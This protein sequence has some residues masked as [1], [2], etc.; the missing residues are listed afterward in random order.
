[1]NK[2][3]IE[4]KTVM[5]FVFGLAVLIFVILYVR[6]G[7]QA[8]SKIFDV[9]ADVAACRATV[10]LMSAEKK[11]PLYLISGGSDVPIDCVTNWV[12]NLTVKETDVE[13]QKKEVLDQVVP[14]VR[15]CWYEFGEGKLDPFASKLV[16]QPNYCFICSRFVIDFDKMTNLSGADYFILKKS[17][18]LSYLESN[19][20]GNMYYS[21]YFN[22]T[23]PFGDPFVEKVEWSLSL[24]FPSISEDTFYNFDSFV[25]KGYENNDYGVVMFATPAKQVRGLFGEKGW[26]KVFIIPYSNVSNLDCNELIKKKVTE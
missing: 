23:F 14:L 17:D 6:S 18:F 9:S 26:Y 4:A 11:T 13:K 24:S 22:D 3:G 16:S 8:S 2:K 15:D 25:D 12:G 19:K 7:G 20:K 5:L 10:E 21:D 1:M